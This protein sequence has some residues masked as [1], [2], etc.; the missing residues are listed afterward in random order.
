L[1]RAHFLIC[2]L[3]VEE[4]GVLGVD[5]LD[6]PL[7]ALLLSLEEFLVLFPHDGLLVVEGSL[8][9]LT[10]F[11][12]GH[13]PVEVRTGLELALSGQFKAFLIFEA[14]TEFTLL[15]VFVDLF[16]LSS[17][18]R[19]LLSDDGGSHSVHEVLGAFL[20][21]R[22]LML[23]VSLLLVE[24][25][26]VFLLS[27]DIF[28]TLL[29]FLS[30]LL[31]LLF[32]VLFEHLFQVHLLLL[33][34]VVEHLT[35]SIHLLLESVN[36]LELLVVVLLVLDTFSLLLELELTVAALLFNLNLGI[37]L[38]LLLHLFLTEEL[39]VFALHSV[40]FLSLGLFHTLGLVFLSHLVVKLLLNE[41][42]ALL[43]ALK[44]LLL[45][46]V[47]QEGV[48][49]LNSEPLIFFINLGVDIGLS[50]L[51]SASRDLRLV[52]TGTD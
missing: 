2:D 47:V 33:S 22:E 41:S 37:V 42:L 39:K 25:A 26:G 18:A 10:V 7:E 4:V 36:K 5:V 19:V 20:T 8:L 21:L 38:T 43:F 49:F 28:L 35:L 52:V 16:V 46:F 3:T 6:L 50:G 34:L 45:L 14:E 13:L 29:L 1:A 48:E 32:F 30:E 9:V 31:G 27:S 15:L 40:I 17:L 23:T 44:S 51:D 24:H 12:F 11:L